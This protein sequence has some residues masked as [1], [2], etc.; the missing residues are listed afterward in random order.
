MITL[1]ALSALLTYPYR[2]LIEVLPEIGATVT[3]SALLGPA[4]KAQVESLIAELRDTDPLEL[5]QRYVALFDTG[6][7]TSLWLFE[8]VHGESRDR[9]Q[10]M[11]DLKNLYEKAGL[12]L[13]ANELPDYLPVVLEYL[14]CREL[15]EA[16]AMLSD[17]AH[18]LRSVGERLA[19]QGSLYAAV[20]DVLLHVAGEPGLARTGAMEPKQSAAESAAHVDD[21]WMD[22]PAFGAGR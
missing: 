15:P 14:S 2:E 18:I 12:A 13:A 8:H 3:Q 19:A 4:Q 16:R 11:V 20:L 7:A 22:A 5:E 17:C 9:G 1:R 10:A 21:E 6:R